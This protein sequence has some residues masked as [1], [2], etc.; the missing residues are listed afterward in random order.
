MTVHKQLGNIEQAVAFYNKSS[1]IDP[2]YVFGTFGVGVL[3]YDKAIEIQ[4]LAAQEVD[5]A[6]YMQLNNQM[7]E[8]LAKSIEPFS[9]TFEKTSDNEIKAAAAEYL[10]NIF[11]RLRDK[12]ASYQGL[13]E[14]YNNFLKGE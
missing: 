11:F 2:N 6:K 5:D 10:K 4:D 3:Y 9:K 12:D 13:Y 1:E 8:T 14:K 7:E